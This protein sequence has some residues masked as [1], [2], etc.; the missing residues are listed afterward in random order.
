[1]DLP[2]FLAAHPAAVSFVVLQV[3]TAVLTWFFRGPSTA[4]LLASTGY[5][6]AALSA[7][8]R[9]LYL[10]GAVGIDS[11]K[12]HAW[13]LVLLTPKPPKPPSLPPPPP[14]V[15]EMIPVTHEPPSNDNVTPPPMA[16]R[17]AL[18]TALTAAMIVLGAA[19]GCGATDV[20]AYAPTPAQELGVVT[21]AGEEQE[22]THLD[23]SAAV[24][25]ACVTKIQCEHGRDAALPCPDAGLAEYPFSTAESFL[26][27][28]GVAR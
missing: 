9:A 8:Q 19:M 25:R 21:Y 2:A 28:N 6:Y 23:A 22:C 27:T 17:L 12:V 11:R 3:G 15:P 13:L 18:F 16:A 14:T 10:L 24:K 20:Q 1:M 26:A 5:T 4:Q 7:W